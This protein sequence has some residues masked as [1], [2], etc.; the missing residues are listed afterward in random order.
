MRFDI[1]KIF[2]IE[3]SNQKW[4]CEESKYMSKI[5]HIFGK[6]HNYKTQYTVYNYPIDLY[7][8]NLAIECDEY[9]HSHYDKDHE[10]QR[11]LIIEEHLKCKWIRFDPYDKHFDFSDVLRQ[12][13]E[14][15]YNYDLRQPYPESQKID[16]QTIFINQEGMYDL[17]M[18]SR[19]PE[20]KIFRRWISHEVLP[21]INRFGSY[22]IEKKYGCFYDD[23][24]LYE[25]DGCNVCYMAYIGVHDNNP[26]FKYGITFDYYRRE[27]QEHRKTFDTFQLLYLRQ[28]D[29]N[30]IIEGLFTKKCKS[31][32]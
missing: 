10:Q 19:K 8:T 14:H 1:A 30:H 4:V 17:V 16:P 25:Y 3:L 2:G 20:A 15:I 26:L 21:T 23:H 27:Y 12:I 24:D 28:T 31:L 29:N 7:F 5:I 9:G 18:S 32:Q 22:S 11:T 6:Y 13:Y